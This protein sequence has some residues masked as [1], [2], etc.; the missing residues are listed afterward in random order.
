ML[1]CLINK[2]PYKRYRLIKEPQYKLSMQ[3]K[4]KI[5]LIYFVFT[6]IL[7]FKT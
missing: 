1:D 5:L 7:I 6:C 2:I 3:F 4:I